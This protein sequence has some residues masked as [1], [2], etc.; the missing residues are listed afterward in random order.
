MTDPEHPEIPSAITD[1]PQATGMEPQSG[2]QAVK[3]VTH[4]IDSDDMFVQG[5]E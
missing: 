3:K 1:E 2:E 4:E 5:G